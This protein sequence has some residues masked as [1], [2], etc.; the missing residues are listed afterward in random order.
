MD[1]DALPYSPPSHNEAYF[2]AKVQR[3]LA[4]WWHE[5]FCETGKRAELPNVI[6]V[7]EYQGSLLQGG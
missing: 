4:Q 3:M 2:S 5:G 6:N 1:L 7:L